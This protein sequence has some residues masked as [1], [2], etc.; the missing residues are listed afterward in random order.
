MLVDFSVANFC[1]VNDAQTLSMV[2][3]EGKISQNPTKIKGIPY[4]SN[5]AAL[6]GAN[7][8]GKTNLIKALHFSQ[9]FI[10]NSHKNKSQGDE[11]GVTPF[12]FD[13]KT[14]NEPSE[15]AISFI[16]ENYFFEYGFEL[17]IKKIHKEY[18]YATDKMGNKQTWFTREN[19]NITIGD[20][21]QGSAK[22][23]KSWKELTRENALFLSQAVQNNSQDFNIAFKWFKQKIKV[24]SDK[25]RS[26]F[27]KDQCFLATNPDC[28]NNKTKILS[29]LKNLDIAFI[30]F[31]I[32]EK[33]T[34]FPTSFFEQVPFEFKE[35]FKK[36][37]LS[38]KQKKVKLEYQVNDKNYFLELEQ[39]SDG[40]QNLFALAGP[41][42]DIL[43]NGYIWIADELHRS[44]HP[45]AFE[46]IIKLFKNPKT[47]PNNAQLIF[48]S[49][50]TYPLKFLD[51]H[52]VWLVEKN[53][54]NL[55]SE[56]FSISEF[57]SVPDNIKLDEEYLDNTFGGLPHIGNGDNV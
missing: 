1:S 51:K 48:T 18:L 41:L 42:F 29:F 11:T 7:G 30:D 16:H 10:L 21:I 36:E 5:V 49:H 20:N 9:H 2:M 32:I 8:A 46:H 39:E 35:D 55:Q 50:N 22:T 34:D 54:D 52:N 14:P 53:K 57:K 25:V 44:L 45:K 56:L 3:P 33:E 23:K 13:S 31:S 4:L 37:I 43:D 19:Q 28:Q 47:N 27:T 26:D 38:S 40:T 17:D 12:L 24:F 6:Y 15:F